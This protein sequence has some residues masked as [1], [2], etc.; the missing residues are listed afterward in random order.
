MSPLRLEPVLVGDV[1]QKNGGPVGGGVLEGA[2]HLLGFTVGMSG[3][4]QLA[5]LLRRDA[6]PGLERG[7]VAAVEVHL[8]LLLEDGGVTLGAAALS[9][10]DRHQNGQSDELQEVELRDRR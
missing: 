5:L 7:V 6:V 9:A 4:L 1:L 10:G 2:L 3:V 8:L